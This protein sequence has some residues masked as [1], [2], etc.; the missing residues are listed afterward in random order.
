MIYLDTSAFLKLY[1]REE[2]SERVQGIVNAQDDPLPVWH[3]LEAEFHNALRLHVFWE[4]LAI[5]QAERLWDKFCERRN[6]GFYFTPAVD[7]GALLETC[8]RLGAST[9]HLGCRTMDLLHVACCMQLG[10]QTLVTFDRRQS[11]MARHAG[12]R[13][14]P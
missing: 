9:P 13:V 7:W 1:V 12:L 10:I 8:H 3:L 4:S 11:A 2:G 14:L 6:A 5:D